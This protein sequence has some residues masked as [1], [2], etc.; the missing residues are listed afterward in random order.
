MLTGQEASRAWDLKGGRHCPAYLK[1]WD[2][3]RGVW[4]ERIYYAGG[5]NH[6]WG[7]YTIGYL[8]WNGSQ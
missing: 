8:E 2:P 4:V 6:V 5:A 1:G 3:D 7:P